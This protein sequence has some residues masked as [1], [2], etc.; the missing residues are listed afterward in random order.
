MNRLR[1]D[2]FNFEQAQ[3]LDCDQIHGNSKHE[4][5][6]HV[7]DTCG[8]GPN[9][10]EQSR[11]KCEKSFDYQSITSQTETKSNKSHCKLS[12]DPNVVIYFGV[13]DELLMHSCSMSL[14]DLPTWTHKPWSRRPRKP[15]PAE[16]ENKPLHIDARIADAHHNVPSTWATEQTQEHEEPIEDPEDANHFLHEAPQSIQNLFDAMQEEGVVTGPRIQESIFL[17]SWFVHQYP[18]ASVFP[19]SRDLR[20][21]DIGDFGIRISLMPGGIAFYLWSKSSLTL[22]TQTH[23]ERLPAM[24][25]Y[26]T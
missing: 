22:F 12:F 15:S 17:R 9:S 23:H 19:V 6:E 1:F 10:F 26:L 11:L 8:A 3:L 14:T 7:D 16:I 24:S 4:P 18:C 20:S 21:M 13:E 5:I 2:P 25:F